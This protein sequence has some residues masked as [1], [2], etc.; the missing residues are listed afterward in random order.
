MAQER[1]TTKVITNAVV[2]SDFRNQFYI[3]DIEIGDQM[4]MLFK[5]DA[6]FRDMHRSADRLGLTWEGTTNSNFRVKLTFSATNS[7]VYLPNGEVPDSIQEVFSKIFS[8]VQDNAYNK[9]T[10][11]SRCLR[12]SVLID[13]D[14]VWNAQWDISRIRI[15]MGMFQT[16]VRRAV[17]G[18]QGWK[19]I[20]TMR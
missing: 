5:K 11:D 1:N 17:I 16:L 12:V 7:P 9:V 4:F 8:S 6:S 13:R 15:A 14:S 3:G 19:V 20:N 18:K 2:D 10:V